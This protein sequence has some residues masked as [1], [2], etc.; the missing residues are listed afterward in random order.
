MLKSD[1]EFESVAERPVALKEPAQ[2]GV[3]LARTYP[4]LPRAVS[5]NHLNDGKPFLR[6]AG[7]LPRAPVAAPS[8]SNE[9][10]SRPA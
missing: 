9:A 3:T 6:Q 10:H 5:D 7:A 2:A 1:D 8:G 4:R